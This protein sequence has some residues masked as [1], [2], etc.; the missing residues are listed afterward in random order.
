MLEFGTAVIFLP[1]YALASWWV[2]EFSWAPRAMSRLRYVH[3]HLGAADAQLIARMVLV[4]YA[5]SMLA[6]L[7]SLVS[8][9]VGTGAWFY[10]DG[11]ISVEILIIVG[12]IVSTVALVTV[13]KMSVSGELA[14]ELQYAMSGY[15]P[16]GMQRHKW[17]PAF[18]TERDEEMQNL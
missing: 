8:M 16:A 6:L 2:F 10:A 5:L 18:E 11:V 12:A 14:M 7:A 4:G 1:F 13:I 15:D 17:F 9:P 3:K